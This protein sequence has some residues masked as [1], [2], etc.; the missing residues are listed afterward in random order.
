MNLNCDCFPL[1]THHRQLTYF[2]ADR[3]GCDDVLF[4]VYK[5]QQFLVLFQ[6]IIFGCLIVVD[7]PLAFVFLQFL[8]IFRFL[9]DDVL[10]NRLLVIQKPIFSV[11]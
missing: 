8:C 11:D 5:F 3:T 6:C 7:L 9:C 2:R 10:Q 1:A 4:G